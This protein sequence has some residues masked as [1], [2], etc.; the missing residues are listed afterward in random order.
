MR[1]V[2]L[3]TLGEIRQLAKKYKYLILRKPAGDTVGINTKILSIG[4][5]KKKS[6]AQITKIY[7]Y[8]PADI[9]SYITCKLPLQGEM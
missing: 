9:N 8:R 4:A 5:N 3:M 2:R 1:R 6:D 7:S